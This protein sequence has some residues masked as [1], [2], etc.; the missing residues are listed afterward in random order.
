[1]SF[2]LFF[3]LVPSPVSHTQLTQPL[4]HFSHSTYS[5]TQLF[6]PLNHSTVSPSLSLFTIHYSL[7]TAL[8]ASDEPFV[9]P[10]NSGLTGLMET[11][12]ARIMNEN[13][14]RI[15]ASQIEPYRYY[16]LNL[17]PF[18][19]F[20]INGR[21]T[22]VMGTVTELGSAYGNYKDK[23]LDFKYQFIREGKYMP[24]I[25]LGVMDPQ[26]TRVY[27]SQFIVANKQIYPF[28]F[29]LGFGNGR[30]GKNPLPSSGESFQIEMFSDTKQWIKD[31]QFFWG[32]QFAP[33]EKF[34]LMMEYSPIKY[35]KQT[36]DPAQA[37]YFQDP[38]PSQFNYGLRIKPLKWTD[39][40]LT[41]QRGNQFGINFSMAFDIGNPIMPIY[42][43]PYVEKPQ[44]KSDSLNDRLTEALH[45]SGFSDIGVKLDGNELW[46]EAQ[47]EK[48]FY[49]TRALGVI[50]KILYDLRP[51]RVNKIN[52]TL[53]DNGIPLIQLNTTLIDIYELFNE[54]LTLREFLRLSEMKTLDVDKYPDIKKRHKKIFDY[55]LKP[56]F[57]T[58]LND[59]SGFFKYRL[60]IAG[61]V[62][63][64]PWSGASLIGEIDAYPINTVSTNQ[65]PL[66]RPVR[67]D[68]VPYLQ[69]NVVLGKLMYQ[70][71]LDFSKG[72]FGRAAGGI[73]EVEYAGIDGEV[74]KSLLGGRLYVGLSGSVVQKRAVDE[75]FQLKS[76]DWKKYYNPWFLNTRFNIPEIETSIEV[77]AGQFLAGDMGARVTVSKTIKGVKIFAWYSFTDTSIFT[78]PYNRGYS[79]KGIG[80]TIPMRLFEGTDS[81]TAYGYSVSPW[82]RDVAQDIEHYTTLF[83]FFGRNSKIYIDKDK[84]SMYK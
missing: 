21:V 69:Q 81:R 34:S 3:H 16:Y 22:E 12:T 64:S 26:G 61:W 76:D 56:D 48:Y 73:L 18:K 44:R 17:S 57:K 60:G 49:N 51:A 70:Q 5:T 84:N 36:R 78:D 63:Y 37:K 1:M 2:L 24:A 8:Y 7:L 72:Y 71:I 62:S 19:G 66:S 11:P 4:N 25:A 67:S 79:D 30:F 53:H 54:K 6:H 42:D 38:V 55:G 33:S 13:S 39:I 45:E 46:I 43:K 41:Y 52:I 29:S 31:S 9:G 82:T 32:I 50:L 68:I 83:D 75:P 77:N 27:P 65:A 23:A 59:P 10:S 40:D 14:F 20:E 28:D 58:F 47:N 74:A 35:D 15:G 80:I